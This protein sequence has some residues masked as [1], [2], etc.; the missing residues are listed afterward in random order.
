MELDDPMMAGEAAAAAAANKHPVQVHVYDA[1]QGEF[2]NIPSD[3]TVTA[4]TFESI[5]SYRAVQVDSTPEIDV[6]D[7][8]FQRRSGEN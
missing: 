5:Y 4:L 6:L 3:V 1:S 8:L 2:E 7:M